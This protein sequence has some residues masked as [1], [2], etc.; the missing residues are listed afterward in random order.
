M[1]RVNSQSAS[2]HSWSGE[3]L[4]LLA[5]FARAEDELFGPAGTLAK[6][7]SEG[8]AVSL[9]AAT[10]SHAQEPADEPITPTRERSCAC[11][12]SGIRRACLFDFPPS[13]LHRV[14]P[15]QIEERLV[16]LIREVRP[17]VIVTFAP[18]GITRAADNQA[19]HH[20]ATAAFHHASDAT[21]FAHHLREG[22]RAHAAQKFY[23][24]VL[25]ASLVARWGVAGLNAV[26]DDRI[27]TKLDV[28]AQSEAMKNALYC[29]RQRALDF[30]RRLTEDQRVEW[31]TEYY[32]LIESRLRRKSRREKDLFAG[33]R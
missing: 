31:N 17:H 16:R 33:L 6:Y 10:H 21:Q 12:A 23:H 13:E 5:I 29:Q 7:A 2:E 27:T 3:K 28:A 9:V 15:E 30:I 11:R 32:I 4:S 25:P 18:E 19:I 8:I 20:A 1:K 14:A 24:C 26:P 22:L